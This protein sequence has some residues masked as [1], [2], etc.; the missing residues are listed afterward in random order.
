MKRLLFFI[1]NL[2]SIIFIIQI[3]NGYSEIAKIKTK[4]CNNDYETQ[5]IEINEPQN[6]M[7]FFLMLPEDIIPVSKEERK[8]MIDSI[9]I[10]REAVSGCYNNIEVFDK[11]GGYIRYSCYGDGGYTVVEIT[12]WNLSD[13][14]RM[15][16]VNN[17]TGGMCCEESKIDFLKFEQGK[18]NNITKKVFPNIKLTEYIDKKDLNMEDYELDAPLLIQL[19]QKGKNIIAKIGGV[20][21]D[22]GYNGNFELIRYHQIIL[23][24]ESDKFV[25]GEKE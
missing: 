9:G 12:Y 6:I 14:T 24:F 3:R 15:V 20:I 10:P 4:T 8:E 5:T 19:P 7:D 13:K 25:I 21:G 18:W 16:A 22:E 1:F 23:K 17:I 2:L 11:G